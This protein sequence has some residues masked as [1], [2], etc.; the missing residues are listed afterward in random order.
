MTT[1]G[2]R[3]AVDLAPA[4]DAGKTVMQASWAQAARLRNR[5]RY[6]DY[7]ALF[8][9][10]PIGD[11]STAHAVAARI[12]AVVNSE[13]TYRISGGGRGDDGRMYVNVEASEVPAEI[14]H[15]VCGTPTDAEAHC[16]AV[17]ARR[18]NLD[19]AAPLWTATVFDVKSTGQPIVGMVC[20]HLMSDGRSL[21]LFER[22]VQGRRG[23]AGALARPYLPW[24]R[25]QAVEFGPRP[26]E[27]GRACAHFW[28]RH[29]Q[30][31]QADE[32]SR[33]DFAIPS[34]F[35]FRGAAV[36]VSSRVTATMA[37][38]RERASACNALPLAVVLTKV[39]AVAV[40]HTVDE[41]VSL[42]FIT[43]GR[44]PGY[45]RTHGFFADS[46]PFHASRGLAA[47]DDAAVRVVAAFLEQ[48][49]PYQD[50]PWD[51]IRTR[52]GGSEVDVERE[53]GDRQL[54]VNLVPYDVDQ[55]PTDVEPVVW[56]DGHIESLHV[57]VG[58]APDGPGHVSA[59]FNPDHFDVA[60]VELFVAEICAALDLSP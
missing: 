43:H 18:F 23:R 48:A 7:D 28:Q 16:R 27:H 60:G 33:L 37:T 52:C 49:S 19:D 26:S 45:A 47:A 54:V 56:H 22:A 46:L 53:P 38:V 2:G 17:S 4:V 58:L 15:V 11:H 14:G 6:G 34:G 21:W 31:R 41:G 12:R 40:R 57:I 39:S 44:P 1:L 32:A 25:H 24:A 30:G 13:E 20:D 5:E 3:A 55:R 51:Y 8:K 42:R 10:F 35:R 50:T 29:L 9:L 59:T 36:T